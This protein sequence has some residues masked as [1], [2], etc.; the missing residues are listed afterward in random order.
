MEPQP[1]QVG[2]L[3]FRDATQFGQSPAS[4]PL[5]SPGSAKASGFLRPQLETHIFFTNI[6]KSSH[7]RWAFFLV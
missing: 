1:I 7:Y 3:F 5:A 6:Q 2:V 4:S